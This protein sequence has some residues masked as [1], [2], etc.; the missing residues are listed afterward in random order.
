MESKKLFNNADWVKF[1]DGCLTPYV[2]GLFEIEKTEKTEIIISGL[3]FFEFYINGKKGTDD[4]FISPWSNYAPAYRSEVRFE[5][6]YEIKEDML[7]RTYAVKY[8]ITDLIKKGKNAIGILLGG[9]WLT[10][11]DYFKSARLCFSIVQN[12]NVIYNSGK[13]LKYHDSF[14][15]KNKILFGEVQDFNKELL[16]WNTTDF[17]DLTWKDVIVTDD[18]GGEY[19]LYNG[20][21]DHV[22]RYIKPKIVK[23][24]DDYTVYDIGENI[25]CFI[26]LKLKGEKGEETKVITAECIYDDG[27]LAHITYYVGDNPH[28]DVYITDGNKDRICHEHFMWQA[29]RYFSVSNNAEV[30]RVGFVHT[31]AEINS[32]FECDNQTLN[33]LYKTF[34]RTQFSNMHCSIPSDCPQREARGYTGDGQLAMG[35]VLSVIE[36]KDFYLKWMEDIYDCQNNTNGHVQYTAPLVASGGGPGG[37]GCAI[38]HVPYMFYKKYGDVDTLR[39]FFPKILKYFEYLEAHSENNLVVSD[40]PWAWCLG[41]WVPPAEVKIPEP[42]VNNYF[43]VRTLNEAIEIAEIIGE[44]DIIPELKQR[45][46]IKKKALIDNYY[47]EKT[48]NFAEDEQGANAMMIDIGLGNEKTLLNTVKKYENLKMYDTGIFGTDILTKVLFEKGYEQ[49][50]FELLANKKEVSFEHMRRN[51]ATTIWENWN[52]EAS[53]SHPMF[54]AVV[55]YLFTHLLGIGQDEGSSKYDKITVSPKFVEG[56][57]NAKGH[58]TTPNGIISVEYEKNGNTADVTVYIPEN[59]KAIFKTKNTEK[60]LE[61]GRNRIIVNI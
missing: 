52:G 39:K 4:I 44:N 36:C 53:H 26:Y 40:E 56:I 60:S 49:L 32:S 48:C 43:Y 45:A 37:W 23:R 27:N 1:E 24:F 25:S 7:Y 50:A 31:D 51:N 35:A 2:R 16:G 57:N 17:D 58:I 38:S 61:T 12:G 19:L 42:L 28:Q 46:E 14:I 9:G 59:I 15:V 3:G 55:Q 29:C 34:I 8:D 10:K 33:W 18:H 47:D 5:K 13:D 41:D 54:G 21:K 22:Q 20:P 11:E 6:R 30:V